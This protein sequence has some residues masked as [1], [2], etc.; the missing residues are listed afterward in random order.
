L[1]SSGKGLLV[2][3]E[4]NRAP[5]YMQGPCLQLLTARRLNDYVLPKGWLPVACVNPCGEGYLTD[6]LDT[7]LASRFLRVEVEPDVAEWLTWAKKN[8]VDSRVCEYVSTLKAFKAADNNPRAWTYASRL[9]QSSER[10]NASEDTLLASLEGV[11]GA[12]LALG[13]L[14]FAQGAEKPLDAEDVTQR[15]H[16]TRPTAMR[17][18]EN[19]RTDL[20]SGSLHR[21]QSFLQA[22]SNW[23][24]VM[25]T[26]AQIENVRQF[27]KDLPGDLRRQAKQ[28]FKDHGYVLGD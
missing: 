10:I 8:S 21:L 4:L 11:V 15:Y 19:K 17:W 9:M 23:R 14:K 16:E 25:E 13:F 20:L 18:K 22:E 28:F 7:A 26:P 5:K 2:F 6:E 3:E 12:E 24:T 27:V 1:P